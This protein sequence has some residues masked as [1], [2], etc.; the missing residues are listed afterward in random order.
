M[1]LDVV[2]KLINWSEKIDVVSC[3][4]GFETGPALFGIHDDL[5]YAIKR[6][7]DKGTIWVNSAGK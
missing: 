1:M 6:L 2:K 3:S 7:T 4:M 5:Y